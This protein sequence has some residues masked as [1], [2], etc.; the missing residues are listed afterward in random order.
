[1]TTDVLPTLVP[2]F[3]GTTLPDWL[4]TRLRAGLGGVCLF[5]TNIESLIQLGNLTDAI[6]AENPR[7]II[8]I[9]EE[10]GDVTRQRRARP[11]RRSRHHRV[12]GPPDR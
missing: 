1:M 11:A 7:A 8:A 6:Y 3:A 12:R 4:K 10:G 2:G 5:A 9:D